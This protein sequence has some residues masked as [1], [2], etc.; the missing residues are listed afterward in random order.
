MAKT[1][2]ATNIPSVAFN[3]TAYINIDSFSHS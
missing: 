3:L 2:S 1:D